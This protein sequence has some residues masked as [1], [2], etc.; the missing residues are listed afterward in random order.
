MELLR[1]DMEKKRKDMIAEI[2][3][4]KNAHIKRLTNEHD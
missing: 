4:K 3:A 1:K 2:E